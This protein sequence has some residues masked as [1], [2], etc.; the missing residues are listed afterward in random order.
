MFQPDQQLTEL[1]GLKIQHGTLDLHGSLDQPDTMHLV[2]HR[3]AYAGGVHFWLTY[4]WAYNQV[5]WA[6]DLSEA[7]NDDFDGFHRVA[8][9]EHKADTSLEGYQRT[10]AML[11]AET[12][13]T[14]LSATF[15]N[16][17]MEY[18]RIVLRAVRND[19]KV[20]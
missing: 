1:Y 12:D 15:A 7:S 16:Y 11:E 9:Y 17:A 20:D 6:V 2:Y 8:S 19:K 14:Q 3:E 18:Y 13:D 4:E 5:T 10:L